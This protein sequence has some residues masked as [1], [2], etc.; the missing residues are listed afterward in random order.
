M[1]FCLFGGACLLG[2]MFQPQ[3]WWKRNFSFVSK[4]KIDEPWRRVW[5]I[6]SLW[7]PAGT[8]T[9]SNRTAHRHWC[10]HFFLSRILYCPAVFGHF[11]APPGNHPRG[12]IFPTVDSINQSS[13]DFHCKPFDRLIDWLI[14]SQLWLDWFIGLVPH[15]LFK[16][17]RG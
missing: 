17:G 8:L 7:F 11:L 4:L 12:A 13:L 9:W 2:W 1:F 3:W 5:H 16:R 14:I 6:Y 10:T 15:D